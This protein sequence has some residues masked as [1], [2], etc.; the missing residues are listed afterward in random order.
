MWFYDLVMEGDPPP[1][2]IRIRD[3]QKTV[4][5]R[6]NIAMVDLLS[7]GR[8]LDIT[9]P[10]QIAMYLCRLMLQTSYPEIGRRFGNRD[11]TTV[12]HAFQKVGARIVSTPEFA[13]EIESLKEE[14][15]S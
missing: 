14:L 13:S 8:T 5:S 12:I 11:H 10:R 4:C 9:L 15:R 1:H 6:Y 7:P 3:I 2:V